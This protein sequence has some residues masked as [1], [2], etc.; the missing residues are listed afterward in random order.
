MRPFLLLNPKSPTPHIHW[1][2][3]CSVGKGCQ[4]SLPCEVSYLQWYYRLAAAHPNTPLERKMV[5][6]KVM[7]NGICTGAPGDPLVQA[8]VLHQTSLKHKTMDGKI[9][10]AKGDGRVG[11]SLYFILRLNARLAHMFPNAWP[12]LDLIQ[13]CPPLV[14]ETAR[15][16]VPYLVDPIG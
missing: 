10:V 6:A 13:G 1:N 2:L 5:Y 12:R 3:D 11:G 9:S 15:A 4:N 14:A 16:T 7:V 8:I